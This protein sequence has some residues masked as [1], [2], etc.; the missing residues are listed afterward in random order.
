MYRLDLETRA[1]AA[2]AAMRRL[3]G[4][5]DRSAMARANA[6]VTEGRSTREAGAGLVRDALGVDAPPLEDTGAPSLA[7]VVGAALAR[8]LVLVG[9][10]LAA[11]VLVGI[12]LGILAARRKRLA[13][14]VLGDD[15]GAADGAVAGAA[16]AADPGAGHRGGAG[17]GRAVSL[18]ALADRAGDVHGA[19]VDPGAARGGGGGA[20]AAVGVP[21]VAGGAAAGVAVD[22]GGREDERGDRGGD[23][24]DRGAGGG[25]G[26]G[27]PILQGIALRNTALILAGAVPAAVLALVA[28]GGFA[29]IERA[30]V[31]KGL[32]VRTHE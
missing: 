14:L 2:F 6:A 29:L 7:G 16:R 1:P 28:Q 17:G 30:V 24:D 32:R 11:C 9:A 22:P 21:A 27:D 13:G 18:R 31:P 4:R 19:D 12:P 23:G 15:G 3:V 10:S 25:G 5:V 20:G 8:H 26:L